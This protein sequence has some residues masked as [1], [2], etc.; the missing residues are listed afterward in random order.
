MTTIKKI[1]EEDYVWAAKR[2]GCEIQ[3]IK[4]VAK[5]EG[6]RSGFDKDGAPKILF[7][8]HKLWKQLII[9]GINPELHVKGNENIL[10]KKWTRAHYLGGEREWER[11]GKAIMIDAES[12]LQSASW[13]MFQVMG[14]HAEALGYRDVF[15]FVYLMTLSE[16]NHLESFV[17]YIETFGL[18]KSLRDKDWNTFTRL[19][20]GHG[21]I[22]YYS[23]KIKK[24]YEDQF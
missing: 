8:G 6:A 21:Q 3:S 15:L 17:R 9:N 19:Y 18:K 2:L 12:A 14:Y 4:A 5:V 1:T 13:G 10:Y 24:A 20:N 16:R 7:E 23:P 11:L 22:S